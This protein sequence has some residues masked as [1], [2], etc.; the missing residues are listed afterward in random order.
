MSIEFGMNVEGIEE[1]QR[2]FDRLPL[3]MHTAVHRSLERV[4]QDIHTAAFRMCA[5]RT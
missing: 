4:G 2:T 1:L 3:L 5:V